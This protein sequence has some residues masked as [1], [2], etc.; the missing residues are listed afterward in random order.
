M[1]IPE[2]DFIQDEVREAKPTPRG[3]DR[4]GWEDVIFMVEELEP[5]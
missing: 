3:Q 2:L 1:D 5:D 4:T